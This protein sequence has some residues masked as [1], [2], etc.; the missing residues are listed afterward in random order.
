MFD[1]R[2]TENSCELSR[3]K[4]G[5]KYIKILF[6]LLINEWININLLNG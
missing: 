5:I 1:P 3:R 6:P 2:E 4:S